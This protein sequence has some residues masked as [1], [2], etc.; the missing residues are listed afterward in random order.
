MT[1]T[2]AFEMDSFLQY[3]ALKNIQMV[4]TGRCITCES[5]CLCSS[6]KVLLS[7]AFPVYHN[8]E[9]NAQVVR[10]FTSAEWGQ[11]AEDLVQSM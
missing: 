10:A 7:G 9:Q 6:T 1:E 11:N 5:R 4:P 2:H 3:E 8:T